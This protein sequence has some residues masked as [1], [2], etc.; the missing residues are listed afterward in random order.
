MLIFS[1]KVEYDYTENLPLSNHIIV[2]V[3]SPFIPPQYFRSYNYY[4][5]NGYKRNTEKRNTEKVTR[6]V[7]D[8]IYYVKHELI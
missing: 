1:D 2:G 4:K 3:L 5:G 6:K 8:K 7:G